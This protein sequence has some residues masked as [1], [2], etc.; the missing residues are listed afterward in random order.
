MFWVEKLDRIATKDTENGNVRNFRREHDKIVNSLTWID[1][2]LFTFLLKKVF[3]SPT[4]VGPCLCRHLLRNYLLLKFTDKNHVCHGRQ[5]LWSRKYILSTMGWAMCLYCGPNY[6][7]SSSVLYNTIH[8]RP[9]AWIACAYNNSI[10]HQFW[11][12]I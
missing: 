7:T 1:M 11:R 4:L 2:F 6:K 8:V 9:D 10:I 12:L 5:A 3:H